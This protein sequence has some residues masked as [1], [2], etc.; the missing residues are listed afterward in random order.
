MQEELPVL[1]SVGSFA[2]ENCVSL[3]HSNTGADRYMQAAPRVAAA[4][5]VGNVSVDVAAS[6]PE[7]PMAQM[8]TVADALRLIPGSVG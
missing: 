6:T 2:G 3:L 8:L 1:Q 5:A 7:V 4:A